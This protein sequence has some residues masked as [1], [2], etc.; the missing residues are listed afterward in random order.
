MSSHIL[1]NTI[2]IIYDNLYADKIYI[3]A[4]VI[5]LQ[6]VLGDSLNYPYVL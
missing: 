5:P 6:S 3:K 2:L 1:V 4:A